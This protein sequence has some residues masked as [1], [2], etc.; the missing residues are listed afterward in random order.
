MLLAFC[1]Y[2]FCH[3]LGT[4]EHPKVCRSP[5]TKGKR[6]MS[7]Q[8]ILIQSSC[9]QSRK[10]RLRTSLH[11]TTA[12]KKVSTTCYYKEGLA[13][14]LLSY[15]SEILNIVKDLFLLA[16]GTLWNGDKLQADPWVHA[17]LN[18]HSSALLMIA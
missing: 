13:E 5:P 1:W 11:E 17:S 4:A 18:L 7:E 8:A 16:W 10:L 15:R 12:Q 9:V 2:V 14:Q 3:L 6:E